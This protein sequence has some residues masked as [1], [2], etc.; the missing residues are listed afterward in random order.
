MELWRTA[1]SCSEKK[2]RLTI[3]RFLYVWPWSL[4]MDW[5][6]KQLQCMTAFIEHT[7][8]ITS[9]TWSERLYHNKMDFQLPQ[10]Q[11]IRCRGKRTWEITMIYLRRENVNPL[12]A[13]EWI[14]IR[15]VYRASCTANAVSVAR[16]GF[17]HM[18]LIFSCQSFNSLYQWGRK[19]ERGRQRAKSSNWIVLVECDLQ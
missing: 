4:L 8:R 15:S 14:C 7:Q 3:F 9:P 11:L 19:T 5:A 18:A 13:G 6:I 10:V 1:V 16:V 17:Q 2:S 12:K